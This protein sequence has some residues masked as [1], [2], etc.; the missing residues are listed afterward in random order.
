MSG[1]LAGLAYTGIAAVVGTICGSLG[2]LLVTWAWNKHAAAKALPDVVILPRLPWLAERGVIRLSLTV[3]NFRRRESKVEILR[4][5]ISR[6]TT[7][8]PADNVTTNHVVLVPAASSEPVDVR[9]QAN[10]EAVDAIANELDLDKATG[11]AGRFVPV[12]T[13]LHVVI[14]G[15]PSTIRLDEGGLLIPGRG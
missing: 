8:T 5:T 15:N 4:I 7:S 2:T 13:E 12:L 9:I 6:V 10:Q 11:R 3:V 14:N 1:G